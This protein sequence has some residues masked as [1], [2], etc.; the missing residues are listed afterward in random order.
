MDQLKKRGGKM[1]NG[2]G[3]NT[4]DRLK[5]NVICNTNIKK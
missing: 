1:T 3:T 4:A 2:M 5:T